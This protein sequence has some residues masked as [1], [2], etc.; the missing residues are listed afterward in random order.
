MGSM[1]RFEVDRDDVTGAVEACGLFASLD[2]VAHAELILAFDGIRMTTGETLM[3]E[4]ETADGL[5]IVR[6][7]RLRATVRGK[8][9]NEVTVGEIGKAEVIGEMAVITDQVRSA[10]IRALRDTDLFRLP[11]E[12]F[13]RLIRHHP[14]MLRPFASVVVE[15]LRTAMTRSA[16]PAL[17]ATVVL[18]PTPG[19]DLHGM[20]MMLAESF[21]PYRTAVL[22][23]ADVEGRPNPAAWLL[24]VENDVDIS[25]LVADAEPNDWTRLCLRHA[26]HVELIVDEH[27][28]P[29]PSAVEADP[30]C[31]QRI[32]E[33]PLH[34]VMLYDRRPSTSALLRGRTLQSHINV[35]KSDPQDFARLSR[36]ITGR[37]NILVLGGGGARGFAH[38]G[39]ARALRE[40]GV[41]VDGIIGTSAGAVVG[42]LL[43]RMH[44]IADAERQMIAWFTSARW[45]RDFNPPSVAVMSGRT[46]TNGLQALGAGFLI[47]DLPTGFA[48]VSCDLVSAEPFVH[49]RGP[50][51]QAVR[52]S[53][54]VP[55]LFPPLAIDGRVLVDGGLV[56]NLPI[57]IARHRHPNARLIAVEVGDPAAMDVGGLDGSGIVNGWDRVI[58]RR[59]V[60]GASLTRLMMRLTELG[61]QDSTD[62]ADVVITPD[63]Q[64]FGLLETRQAQAIIERGYAAGRQLVESGS[65][66]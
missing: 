8:D 40:G 49:D 13:A 18:L 6:H 10:T 64:E 24:D 39:V 65:L 45:R 54:S 46:M 19:V 53:G 66:R 30:E 48:A 25:L 61:R 57:D 32:A 37:A 1:V 33:L 44:D 3:T 22:T 56:A 9:G 63:V 36:M 38:F 11:A 51:W 21:S 29:T 55:G 41:P 42:G 35:R 20:A 31:R 14:E 43:A 60:G 15:R 23:A 52:A 5:Y 26:D 17:P 28:P 16:R 47:E 50:L 4:G 7:G 12:A 58:R 59:G 27:T 2:G 34:L 62:H